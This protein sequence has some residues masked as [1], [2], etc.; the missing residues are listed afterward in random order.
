MRFHHTVAGRQLGVAGRSADQPQ[1]HPVHHLDRGVGQLRRPVLGEPVQRATH[2]AHLVVTGEGQRLAALGL[3]QPGQSELQHRQRRVRGLL[4]DQIEQSRLEAHAPGSG[5]LF[6]RLAQLPAGQ[7]G[8]QVKPVIQPRMA[9]RNTLQHLQEIRAQ[10]QHHPA[11]IRRG[12]C[13]GQQHIQQRLICRHVP[14][15][16][17]FELVDHQEQGTVLATQE[18]C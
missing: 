14:G 15:K 17:F 6:D 10:G 11:C 13:R 9:A 8:Q 12:S 4:Q 3:P 18:P 7:R 2:T 16:Q 5:G 1:Q